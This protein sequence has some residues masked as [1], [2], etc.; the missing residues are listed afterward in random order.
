MTS[1]II[2]VLIALVAILGSEN[3]ELRK[4]IQE[5]DSARRAFLRELQE[6]NEKC[7]RRMRF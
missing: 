3:L 4:E 1:V 7:L 2:G 5:K 6:L